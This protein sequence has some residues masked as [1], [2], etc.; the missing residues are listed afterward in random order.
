MPARPELDN[1][2]SEERVVK[3]FFQFKPIKPGYTDR[4]VGVTGKI[5]IEEPCVDEQIDP[6][7]RDALGVKCIKYLRR[8]LEQAC[9]KEDLEKAPGC[10]QGTCQKI[11]A[12][13]GGQLSGRAFLDFLVLDDRAEDEDRGEE[14]IVENFS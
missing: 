10:T 7:R 2:A 4:D 8:R 5:Y 1:V 11:I 6:D 3:I 9:Q 13:R 12:F 14:S